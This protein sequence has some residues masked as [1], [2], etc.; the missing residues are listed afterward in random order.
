[1]VNESRVKNVSR[2]ITYGLCNRVI[3]ILLPFLSRT[4]I[5]YTLGMEYV[6]LN[7]LFSSV[8]SVLSLTELGIGSALVYSMYAPAARKDYA[9]MGSFLLFYKKCYRMIGFL[10]LAI[11]LIIFPFLGRLI[12]GEHPADVNLSVLY[13]VYLTN[14]AVSYFMFAYKQAVF[15][16]FQ[17]N[18]LISNISSVCSIVLNALQILALI[19]FKNYYAYVA[20]IPFLTCV[21]NL[22]SYIVAK[23]YYPYIKENGSLLKE[24]L[25]KVRKNVCG[26]IYQKIGGIILTS[27]DSVVISAFLGLTVLGKYNSYYYIITSILSVFAVIQSSIVSSIGNSLIMDPVDKNYKDFK[28]FHFGYNWLLCWA[29]S[30]FVCLVQPFVELWIGKENLFSVDMAVLFAVYL[31]FYKVN[32]MSYIY[33][34][35]A[36]LWS[37]M[38]LAPLVAA[39]LNLVSNVCLVKAIGLYGILVSTILANIIVYIPA[40]SYVVFKHYFHKIEK[41]PEHFFSI[42]KNMLFTILSVLAS[43]AMCEIIPTDVLIFE[44]IAR[45]VICIILPNICL[46]LLTHRT[47]EYK[48]WKRMLRLWM[49]RGKR[50]R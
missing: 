23:K 35:A 50:E 24:D 17:R 10:I 49:D 7:S 11:G 19:I 9:K 43:Y 3:V 4:A 27:T 15:T 22:I 1:M 26:L 30:G 42:L 20:V 13:F 2:N 12:S 5:I 37:C 40:Y 31:F 48:E 21:N 38:K 8:L 6:G 46:C 16:A 34:E 36:G 29:V 14:T 32:D 28:K 39:V 41:L 25:I 44:F 18:D 45:L 33:R 47:M